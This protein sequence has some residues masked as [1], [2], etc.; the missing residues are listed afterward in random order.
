MRPAAIRNATVTA[1]GNCGL[2]TLLINLAIPG[3]GNTI[4]LKLGK[5][6]I[7]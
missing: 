1:T 3:S 4:T 7:G 5:A 2:A 6:K